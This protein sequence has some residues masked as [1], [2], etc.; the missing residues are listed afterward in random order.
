MNAKQN[1]LFDPNR[2]LHPGVSWRVHLPGNVLGV[3][4]VFGALAL[5][6]TVFPY[7]G[8][9]FAC[10]LGGGLLVAAGLIAWHRRQRA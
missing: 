7:L 3:L 5:G 10:A 9:F 2:E 6:I 4:L 8:W 1:D